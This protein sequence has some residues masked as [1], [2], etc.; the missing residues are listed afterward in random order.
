MTAATRKTAAPADL[1]SAI[2]ACALARKA[3]EAATA[4][5]STAS[6]RTKIGRDR[7]E[8]AEAAHAAVEA[9]NDAVAAV[10]GQVDHLGLATASAE[11]A[12]AR[13]ELAAIERSVRGNSNAVETL[14]QRC[15]DAHDQLSFTL[16]AATVPLRADAAAKYAAGLQLLRDA[17]TITDMLDDANDGAHVKIPDSRGGDAR[18]ITV[19]ASAEVAMAFGTFQPAIFEQRQALRRL[20][21]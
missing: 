8:A 10:G 7:V 17:M 2:E 4:S 9:E 20:L 5:Q 11:L 16:Q 12:S 21:R 14:R 13:S 6:V 1:Q 18:W 15:S 19:R 3:F